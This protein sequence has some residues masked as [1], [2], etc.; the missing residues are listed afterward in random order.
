MSAKMPAHIQDWWQQT[1]PSGCQRLEIA[2]SAGRPVTIAYGEAGTGAPLLLLHGLGSWSYSWRHNVQPLSQQHRVICVDA[3]G[4]GFSEAAPLPETAGHQVDELAQII[5]ALSDQ[6]VTL[7]AE[8]L[9]GLTALAAAQSYPALIDRLIVI[10]LPIF[11]KELP[12]WGMR[13]LSQLPLPLIQRVDDWRMLQPCAPIVEY[14]TRLV[15]AE[16]VLDPASITDAEIYWLTYPYLHRRGTLTQFAVDLQQAAE[17]I[18]LCGQRQPNLISQIQRQLP[19]I[20][21]PTLVLWADQDQW[22]PA[23]DGERLCQ[24]LP[25]AQFQLIPNCGHVASSG[26]PAALNAAILNFLRAY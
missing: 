2:D 7:A 8:S 10:N 15:R 19:E 17:Q 18:Q 11:P 26:N 6:P 16:V 1:F 9:G 24:Q 3:K 20:T 5:Q 12:N 14:L 4:Y 22:F 13:V 25:N 21:A 23:S